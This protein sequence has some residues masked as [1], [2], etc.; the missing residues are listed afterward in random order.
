[1][2]A[3]KPFIKYKDDFNASAITFYM[4]KETRIRWELLVSMDL[5]L[6]SVFEQIRHSSHGKMVATYLPMPESVRKKF[7]AVVPDALK[8]LKD[9]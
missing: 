9:L 4:D 1:M 5:D 2:A 6:G 3:T 7:D 8:I